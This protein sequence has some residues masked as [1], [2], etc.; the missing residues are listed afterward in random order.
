M[1]AKKSAHSTEWF[2]LF[3]I[4]A[5]VVLYYVA[6]H[7]NPLT[8]RTCKI[9]HC[10]E[11][12]APVTVCC[13]QYINDWGSAISKP[14]FLGLCIEDASFSLFGWRQVYGFCSWWR[15]VFLTSIQQYF[16]YYCNKDP[17]WGFRVF[18]LQQ[19]PGTLLRDLFQKLFP[20]RIWSRKC[21][22]GDL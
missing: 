7:H 12:Q 1:Q 14:F 16:V 22:W 11:N 20:P 3:F 2:R 17:G 19:H 8:I 4:I 5:Y 9:K 15:Q 21:L 18:L 6:I 13:S 10:W